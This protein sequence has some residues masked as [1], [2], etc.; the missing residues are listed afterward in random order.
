MRNDND[1]LS[2]EEKQILLNMA[3]KAIELKVSGQDP[4]KINLEAYPETLREDHATFVTLTKNGMLRGCI[5]TLEAYQPLIQDVYEH[6][7]DAA[8]E[9]FRF[10]PVK[11]KEVSQI[12][13]EI[14]VLSTPVPLEFDEP[15]E[16][17]G[18]LRVG[19]DG[20]VISNG[21]R[22]S[23]FL[24]QVWEKVPDPEAFMSQLCYKMGVPYDYWRNNIL[25]VST[26]QV[27]EFS[28]V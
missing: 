28:E 26:Y 15:K 19:I 8:F 27:E 16:I 1:D 10:P 7:I 3:R 6:A 9:D 18:K 2:V 13:I 12:K 22:R 17:L 11:A 4:I 24:P 14:S 25:K 21:I 23:T 20:V 5:G